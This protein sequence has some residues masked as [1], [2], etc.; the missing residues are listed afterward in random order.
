MGY[1]E[2]DR[3][4]SRVVMWR[5]DGVSGTGD[6]FG[7]QSYSARRCLTRERKNSKRAFAVATTAPAP[8]PGATI[9]PPAAHVKRR[10]E[11]EAPWRGTEAE[12]LR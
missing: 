6:G 11:R 12:L 9:V 4:H 5:R 1:P 7:L 3:G 2:S 10:R 8:P